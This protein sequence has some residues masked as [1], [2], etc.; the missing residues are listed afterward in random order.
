MG[1]GVLIGGEVFVIDIE[2]LNESFK[3]QFLE[4]DAD[5]AHDTGLVCDYVISPAKDHVPA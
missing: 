1:D 5:A 3:S 2:V 4:D